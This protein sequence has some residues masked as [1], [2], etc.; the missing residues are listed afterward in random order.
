MF[1]K[2]FLVVLWRFE[3]KILAKTLNF[4]EILKILG[5]IFCGLRNK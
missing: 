1:N 2:E 5:K 3:L 4:G